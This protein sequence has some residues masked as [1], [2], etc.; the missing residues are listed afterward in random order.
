MTFSFVLSFLIILTSCINQN[1]KRESSETKVSTEVIS[2]QDSCNWCGT[3][4]APEVVLWQT[5]IPPEGEQGE[6]LIISG[7]VYLPDGSTPA[8]GV[9]IYVHHTNIQGVYP[10][11]GNEKGNGNFHG[12]LRGWMKTDS[13]GRYKFETIR[14]AP[15]QTHGGEPAHIHYNIEGPDHPEYW[16]TALW[17]EDDPR[18]TEDYLRSVKRNGGFSNVTSLR[19]D[20]NGILRGIRN[21]I[22]EKFED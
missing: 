1:E 19:K 9:L 18:V 16:L 3:S 4:E 14:P 6:R 8:E 7:T 21:I 10:K 20:E 12:Y 13:L 5:I 17:F 22:L 15:Y 2:A 11:R